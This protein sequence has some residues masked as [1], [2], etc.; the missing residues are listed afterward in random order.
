[1][2]VSLLPSPMYWMQYFGS[3][4]LSSTIITFSST[5]LSLLSLKCHCLLPSVPHPPLL[6]LFVLC[7]HLPLHVGLPLAPFALS[8]LHHSLLELNPS[9]FLLLT[10]CMVYSLSPAIQTI[11]ILLYVLTCIKNSI[12]LSRFDVININIMVFING[13]DLMNMHTQHYTGE[14]WECASV[15]LQGMG[16]VSADLGVVSE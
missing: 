5:A 1:M 15:L 3:G 11:H 7:C 6:T 8:L 2:Q 13:I 4:L 9:P 10:L 16:F 12:L 14:V